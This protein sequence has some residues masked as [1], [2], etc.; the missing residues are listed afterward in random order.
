MDADVT[1]KP[2]AGGCELWFNNSL[3]EVLD[4]DGT[5]T[6]PDRMACFYG[7]H[8]HIEAA[9]HA[10]IGDYRLSNLL[11]DLHEGGDWTF[12]REVSW[13]SVLLVTKK[14][15]MV[16]KMGYKN[17]VPGPGSPND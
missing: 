11:K 13:F 9:R 17:W 16:N 8:A 3:E 15:V 10:S 1:L 14:S 5:P 12:W 7:P 2:I 6:P 4:G